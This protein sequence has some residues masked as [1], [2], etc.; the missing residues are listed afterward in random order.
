MFQE[1]HWATKKSKGSVLKEKLWLKF[2]WSLLSWLPRIIFW[3]LNIAFI[4]RVFVCF[5]TFRGKPINSLVAREDINKIPKFQFLLWPVQV[6]NIRNRLF[7]SLLFPLHI[8]PSDCGQWFFIHGLWTLH[9]QLLQNTSKEL[10]KLDT[11]W[12]KLKNQWDS[13]RSQANFEAFRRYE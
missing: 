3:R 11:Q 8:M 6:P 12:W 1:S 10:G 7:S 4:S 9:L 5:L 2:I 13:R